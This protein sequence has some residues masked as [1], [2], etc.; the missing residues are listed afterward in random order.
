MT[1]APVSSSQHTQNV[2]GTRRLY[3]AESETA[4]LGQKLRN[5]LDRVQEVIPPVWPIADYVAINP[6]FGLSN[7]PFLEA[8]RFLKE[9]SDCEMLMPLAY[10]AERYARGDVETQ[11]IEAAVEELAHDPRQGS[12][13]SAPEILRQLR[14]ATNFQSPPATRNQKPAPGKRLY[15]VAD[16]FDQ[17]SGSSWKELIREEVGKHCA[18]HYDEGQAG[19]T[20][21]WKHLPLYQA[22]RESLRWDRQMEQLGLTG[23][24]EKVAAL[25]ES[26]EEAIFQLLEQLDVPPNLWEKVLLCQAFSIPGWCGWVKYQVDNADA[27]DR[28][29]DFVGLLAIKLAYDAALAEVFSIHVNWE[30]IARSGSLEL[31]K[32]SSLEETRLRFTL[33]RACE[34]AYRRKLLG[35]LV[36]PASQSANGA[37]AKG[38]N[39]KEADHAAVSKFAHM[40]FCIDVRSERYRRQIEAISDEVQT[41][42]FA[43]FFGLPIEYI[44][45]GEDQGTRQVPVLLKPQFA[46]HEHLDSPQEEAAVETIKR[47]TA[48]RLFRSVWKKF[49]S[50]ATSCFPFVETS[51]WLYGIKLLNRSLSRQTRSADPKFDGLKNEQKSCLAPDFAGLADQ[52]VSLAQQVDLAES[53]LTNL[54]MTSDF[55]RLVVFCGHGSQTENNPLQ[56]GLDCGA[57]GGHSGESNARLAARLLNSIEVR[58]E[59]KQ[60]G[61]SIPNA[62]HFVAA[63]HNTTNDVVTFFDEE[64]IPKTHWAAL[65]RLRK[66]TQAATEGTQA[67]RIPIVASQTLQ[68]LLKRSSDWSEIRPEWGL[69]GNAAFI[70]GPRS[71]TRDANLEGRVF[72]HDYDYRLD[73]ERKVLT[74]IMTAPMIVAHW[75]NMQYYASTVDQKHFGS[76]T[77]TI[78]N[79]VGGFGIYSGNGGDLMTGLP[80]ESLHNGKDYQHIPLRLQVF[81]ACPRERMEHVIAENELV[82]NLL[83]NG[84]LSLTAIE[85]S[86]CYRYT[87]SQKWQPLNHL[88][89]AKV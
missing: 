22:W 69:A 51:G 63:L 26:P 27:S 19:W 44:A 66:M 50:T 16:F 3:R 58:D 39:V 86:H 43:G 60:R 37:D 35:S 24:R 56:A 53:V 12:P 77:K 79:V 10:F 81:I 87:Q 9:F 2:L 29:S 17:K 30:A 80:W 72:L 61:I 83:V 46:V 52:G 21:P 33:Q 84:W 74:Q 11:D 78:H 70:A 45:L 8:E 41:S 42:G 23:F 88:S 49:Q 62:T 20:S 15:P 57:C 4:L 5:I 40:V 25:S 73:P 67:E 65:H 76:G 7:R 85:E 54:G 75:I 28:T 36:L 6:Y 47:R 14:T 55:A 1:T 32:Q 13:R 18:A 38:G 68:D 71:L 31:D 82:K 34:I 59:L 89:L 64:R 48:T